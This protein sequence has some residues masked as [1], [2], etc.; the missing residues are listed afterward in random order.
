MCEHNRVRSYCKECGGGGLCL[1][2]RVRSKCKD[3][4]GSGICIHGRHKVVPRSAVPFARS[5]RCAG[6]LHTQGACRGW[7]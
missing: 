7:D 1:H 2:N 6:P 4:G 5:P 3:C